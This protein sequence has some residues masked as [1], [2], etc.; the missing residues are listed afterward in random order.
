MSIH[1]QYAQRILAGTKRV[2]FRKRPIADDVTHVIVYATAPVSAVVGAFEVEAQ[3]TLNPRTLWKQFRTVAGIGWTDYIAYYDGRAAGTG[4][5]V[6][7]VLKPDE[8]LCLLGELGIA[9]PPQS[10]QYVHADTARAALAAM[11]PA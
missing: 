10:F 5:A 11:S 3:H 6:G 2:E 9:R 8:P 4:I 1:P 7:K